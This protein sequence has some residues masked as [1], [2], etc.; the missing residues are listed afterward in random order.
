MNNN[1][2]KKTNLAFYQIIIIALGF[3]SV[4]IFFGT[5]LSAK[6][7]LFGQL[8]SGK[9]E[10]VC[11]CTSQLSFNSHPF[12]FSALSIDSKGLALAPP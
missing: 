3:F 7:I 2:Q 4:I 10:S 9:L 5:M 1:F 6:A 11:G 8:L 12:I